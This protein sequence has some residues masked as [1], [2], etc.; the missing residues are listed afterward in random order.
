[1]SL[2]VLIADD[3]ERLRSWLRLVLESEGF[4]VVE[5]PD[6][7]SAVELAIATRPGLALLDLAMPGAD[8]IEAGRSIRASCPETCLL[9]LTGDSRAPQIVEAFSSGFRGYVVKTD[10]PDDLLRAIREVRAGKIFLS[11]AASRAVIETCAMELLP[12]LDR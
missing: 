10:A 9:L 8:G 11:P 3:D 7:P 6:G 4:L 12:A 1:M 5:A 2:R